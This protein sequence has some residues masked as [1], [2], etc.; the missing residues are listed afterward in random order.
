[1]I[2]L[3]MILYQRY[4]VIH[5]SCNH[6][7]S[8]PSEWTPLANWSGSHS[9]AEAARRLAECYALS[10]GQA[11]RYVRATTGESSLAEAAIKDPVTVRIPRPLLAQ[12]RAH[13]RRTGRSLGALMTQALA[14]WLDRTPD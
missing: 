5:D 12:L 4:L 11:R 2:W 10:P 3:A 8:V 7:N 9:P 1:M 13:A 6:A 14:N